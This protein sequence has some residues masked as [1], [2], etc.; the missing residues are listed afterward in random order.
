MEDGMQTVTPGASQ[1][2]V[3]VV[4]VQ[5]S[6]YPAN[7]LTGSQTPA[8]P[9]VAESYGEVGRI[10]DALVTSLTSAFEGKDAP[11][12]RDVAEAIVTLA[13]QAKG[14]CGVRTVVGAPFGSDQANGDVAPV[15]SKVA[16]ALGLSHLEKVA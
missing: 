11:D 3:E 1:L 10:P 16:E 15:Q 4:E 6:A 9:E 13:G 14:S 2:G 8:G 5:P 7:F 12:P